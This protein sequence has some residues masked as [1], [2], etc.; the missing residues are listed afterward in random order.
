MSRSVPDA[1]ATAISSAPRASAF[2]YTESQ[3]RFHEGNAY[4]RL[5]K[6]RPALQAQDRALELCPPADYTDWAMIRLD[7]AACM[8]QGGDA[9]AAVAY[10]IETLT[11]LTT[12]QRQGIIAGRGREL[13]QALP[14]A[15]RPA[16]AGR[17]FEELLMRPVGEPKEISGQ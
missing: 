1:T 11:G 4:T 12:E 8:A 14:G 6:I 7:R 15:Y 17:E 10:A 2:G 5:R 13:V 9:P 3:L 16:A